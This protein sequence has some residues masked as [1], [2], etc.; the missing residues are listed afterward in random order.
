MPWLVVYTARPGIPTILYVRY[1]PFEIRYFFGAFPTEFF[2]AI[3]GYQLHSSAG[4]NVTTAYIVWLVA[5]TVFLCAVIVTVLLFLREDAVSSI[6]PFPTA[7]VLG[8]LLLGS[9]A[10]FT[11]STA[12]FVTVGIGGVPLPIGVVFMAVFGIILLLNPL[13]EDDGAVQASEPGEET[14]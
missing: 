2:S 1:A 8:G 4:D 6:L 11:V 9:A 12:L 7:R 3:A 10:L 5:S 13:D 14:D